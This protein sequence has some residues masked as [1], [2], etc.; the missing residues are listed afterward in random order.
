MGLNPFTKLVPKWKP[1]NPIV[2]LFKNRPIKTQNPFYK[3]DQ[4]P[5][6]QIIKF[7]RLSSS[8]RE[9]SKNRACL[10]KKYARG[11]GNHLK[12]KV[13][14]VSEVRASFINVVRVL[15][16]HSI[17]KRYSAQI[18]TWSTKF[19]RLSKHRANLLKF[20]RVLCFLKVPGSLF[21]LR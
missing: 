18:F 20:A 21:K 4:K 5:L 10:G 3:S 14:R 11:L 16:I 15:Q 6:L 12:N 8:S 9:F 2:L 19:A 7:V 17:S 13:A 1:I